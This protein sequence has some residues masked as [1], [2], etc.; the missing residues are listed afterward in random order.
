MIG[1]REIAALRAKEEKERER[2]ALAE[3]KAKQPR[4]DKGQG[5]RCDE[6]SFTGL[7][8]H[9]VEMREGKAVVSFGGPFTFNIASW[10][11][12]PDQL[13]DVPVLAA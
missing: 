9:V 11:L 6:P 7:V 5:V 12:Q 8:G 4:F 10:L 3:R 2:I 13:S 1:Y